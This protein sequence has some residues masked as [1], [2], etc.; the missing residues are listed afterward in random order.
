MSAERCGEVGVFG[1]ASVVDTAA[2]AVAVAP[3]GT[4]HVFTAYT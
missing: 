4:V 1:K 2:A 3:F